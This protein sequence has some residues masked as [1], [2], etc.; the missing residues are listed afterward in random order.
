MAKPKC[1][2]CP[3]MEKSFQQGHELGHLG[4]LGHVAQ[5]HW[6]MFILCFVLLPEVV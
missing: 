4:H 1:E 3:L 6:L 2:L 5:F